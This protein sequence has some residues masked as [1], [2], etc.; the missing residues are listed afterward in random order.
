MGSDPSMQDRRTPR[1]L[2]DLLA[3][4]F[5]PFALDAFAEEHNA[6]CPRYIGASDDGCRQR[7]EDV[8]FANP[9]FALMG[10]AVEQA[11]RESRHGVR[12]VVIGPAGC[13]QRWYHEHAIR[14]TIYV[15][16]RRVNYDLPDGTP[17][18][19]ADRD[20]IVIAFGG[21]HANSAGNVRRGVF[22]VKR[23]GLRRET[24]AAS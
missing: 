3:E 20:S 6:L 14:G 11:V 1:W 7:W 13:S 19:G 22:A 2:F 21:A 5:G 24:P 12:S 16:D 18:H 8:T 4:R 9:P 15:P 17:T 10:D 23:L